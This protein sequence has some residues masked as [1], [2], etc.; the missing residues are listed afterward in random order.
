MQ[1]ET[2]H[3]LNVI[4]TEIID[5]CVKEYENK[6]NYDT[7]LMRKAE[8]IDCLKHLIP[9]IQS[10]FNQELVYSVGNFYQHST[11]YLPHTDYKKYLNNHI[12]VVIPLKNSEN[13]AH[14]IIFDQE[15]HYD[16]I[17]WC[18][19]LPVQE[20]Q[21][22]TG[23]KGSPYEYPIKNLTGKPIDEKLYKY[24]NQYPIDNLF[25]LSGNAYP[26]TVGSIL[27][28]DNRRI[29]CTSNFSGYK[30]GITLR[31]GFK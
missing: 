21:V 22:N 2:I 1:I 29:H 31:F 27:A 4:P 30:T 28:F 9:I 14:L 24:C 23:V 15:W 26:F 19:H 16:S 3:K 20:F 7:I 5:L 17:T 8:P 6:S 11:P 13:P 25:G 18:M 12:N 10:L